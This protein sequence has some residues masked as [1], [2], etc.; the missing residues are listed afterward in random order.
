MPKDHGQCLCS[1]TSC[2]APTPACVDGICKQCDSGHPCSGCQICSTSSTCYD[3]SDQCV[4]A[5]CEDDPDN[6][7]LTC[8]NGSCF[9]DNSSCSEGETCDEDGFCTG[10]GGGGGG[11]ECCGCVEGGEA[12]SEDCDCAEGNCIAGTCQNLDPIIVDLNG[13][14][15]GLTNAQN[16]VKFDFF[17]TGS[18]VQIPWTAAGSSVGW[19]ALDRHNDGRVDNGADLFSNVA[20]QPEAA[21][22]L[23][24]G[25]KAL[26]VYDERPTAGTATAS[27]T[28]GTRSFPSSSSG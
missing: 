25:F 9:T 20:P 24:I 26:A 17:G 2:S 1:S 6:C 10:S 21:P 13:A 18:P 27:S 3:S 5:Y 22:Q 28:S 12:C 23:K 16:G 19:L 7:C 14:G 4:A 8:T 11:G 15:F